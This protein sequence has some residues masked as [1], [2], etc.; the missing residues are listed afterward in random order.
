MKGRPKQSVCCGSYGTTHDLTVPGSRT[1]KGAC[2]ACNNIRS[3]LQYENRMPNGYGEKLQ[4]IRQDRG[5][6]QR[7]IAAKLG[8]SVP[9]VSAIETGRRCHPQAG[10][11]KLLE[12][13]GVT[14]DELEQYDTAAPFEIV[15]P[16]DEQPAIEEQRIS[17]GDNCDTFDEGK[18]C[19]ECLELWLQAVTARAI[20][21]AFVRELIAAKGIEERAA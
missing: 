13:Y 17:H 4:A 21:E 16:I 3:R 12:A 7:E 15:T 10:L 2:R 18:M 5:I 6:T 11:P 20:D 1:S 9:A 14:P 19:R 8:I